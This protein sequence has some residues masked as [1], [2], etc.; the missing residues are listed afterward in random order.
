MEIQYADWLD[1]CET[2]GTKFTDSE[3]VYDDPRNFGGPNG[4]KYCR[5]PAD[6]QFIVNGID[7]FDVSQGR[8]GNCWFLSSIAALAQKRKFIKR[9]LMPQYNNQPEAIAGPLVNIDFLSKDKV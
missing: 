3:F 7:A 4:S 5:L 9:V 8:I 6:A 2:N 1:E